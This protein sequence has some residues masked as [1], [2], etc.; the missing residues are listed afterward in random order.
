M[1]AAIQ[2]AFDA[3]SDDGAV[4]YFPSGKYKITNSIK[5][6]SRILSVVGVGFQSTILWASNS[7]LFVWFDSVELSTFSDFSIASV[8]PAK[9][10]SLVAFRFVNE[11]SKSEFRQLLF[12]GQPSA[13][14]TAGQEGVNFPGC[15]DMGDVTDTVAVTDSVAWM[16]VGTIFKIGRGSEVRINGGRL[17]GASSSQGIGIHLTGNNGGVHVISSDVIG[18]HEGIR[19]ENSSGAGSN[20]EVFISQGTIDSNYVGLALYDNSYVDVSGLWFASSVRDNIWVSADSTNARI[21]LTG[22]TIFNAGALGGDPSSEC[23]GLTVN[24][25]SFSLVGVHIRNNKG[26]GIWVPNGNVKKY[27]ISGCKIYEN[28]Q[29]LNLGGE[30]YAVTGN[31][32]SDNAEKSDFGSRAGNAMVANNLCLDVDDGACS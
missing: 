22:G 14:V 28:G 8:A 9:D 1:T 3:C 20:R 5:I 17:V 21:S 6:A 23:N 13:S 27:L 18:L 29:G 12:Y 19:I 26:R 7:D 15:I 24:A 2:K 4:I 32:V 11:L 10:I 31:I 25:G 16:A 30:S